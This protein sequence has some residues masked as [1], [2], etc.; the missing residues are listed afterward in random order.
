M[1][2]FQGAGGGFGAGY[3]ICYRGCGGGSQWYGFL[4]CGSF[5]SPLPAGF[6]EGVVGLFL[7]FIFFVFMAVFYQFWLLWVWWELWFWGCVGAVMG[8]SFLGL[9]GASSV[10]L[11]L[12]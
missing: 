12:V 8:S 3:D 1:G 10:F 9:P 2:F 7:S 11:E 4:T 5:I 6:G